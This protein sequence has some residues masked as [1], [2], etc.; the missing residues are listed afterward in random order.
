MMFQAG[1]KGMGEGSE[2]TPCIHIYIAV[3]KFMLIVI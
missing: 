3:P 2:L 1:V